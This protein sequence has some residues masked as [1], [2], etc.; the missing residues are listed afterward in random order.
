MLF[1]T[2]DFVV[3]VSY[4]VGQVVGLAEQSFPAT[5][6]RMYYEVSLNNG[7]VWVPADADGPGSLRPLSKRPELERCRHLLKSAPVDLDPDPR[8]RQ[9]DLVERL[10]T[11][12]MLVSCE[13][14]RDLTARSWKKS[15]NEADMSSLRKAREV[16][17]QE[18]AAIAGKPLAEI[19]H[20]IEALLRD[21]RQSLPDLT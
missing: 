10:K 20:E 2:G 18:W 9:A 13:V 16:L 15:L 8:K 17:C 19:N 3:H 6:T 7:T 1:K 4:G 12:S 21:S 14:V 11:G 5:Q